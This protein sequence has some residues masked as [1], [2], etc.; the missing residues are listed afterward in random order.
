MKKSKIAILA[1]APALLCGCAMKC[2]FAKF[3]EKVG[4][5]DASGVK[6]SKIVIKGKLNDGKKD[7][8]INTEKENPSLE[9]AAGNL[10]ASLIM[11]FNHVALY[12]VAEDTNA[13]Y[14]AGSTFKVKTDVLTINWDKYGNCVKVSGKV[15]SSDAGQTYTAKLTASYTYEAK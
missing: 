12:S 13:A 3:Q 14:Y 4:A 8:E 1:L 6:V 9:E 2:D 5:I 11:S 10:A 15:Q 7:Y